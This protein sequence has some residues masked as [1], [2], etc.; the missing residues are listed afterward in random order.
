MYPA[1]NVEILAIVT[2]SEAGQLAAQFANL[3]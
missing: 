1:A 3:A 2:K